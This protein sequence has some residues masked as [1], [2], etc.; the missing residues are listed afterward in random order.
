ML[1][2]ARDDAFGPA[3]AEEVAASLAAIR[4]TLANEWRSATRGM[5]SLQVVED[6]ADI[7]MYLIAARGTPHPFVRTGPGPARSPE[8]PAALPENSSPL[9]P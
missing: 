6:S 2:L 8:S 7:T 4:T 1:G 5:G 3:A 9:P